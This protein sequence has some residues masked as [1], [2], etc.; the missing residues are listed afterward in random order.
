MVPTSAPAG[1][2]VRTALAIEP[3]N[4]RLW[5][6]LPPVGSIEDYLDL[7]AAVEDTAA[8]L[9]MPVLVEGYPPP[10]DSR[11]RVIKGTVAEVRARGEPVK[12]SA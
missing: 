8:R 4:G 6:F 12:E 9:E 7:I 1:T 10:Y 5:V 3:R 2:V 11:V